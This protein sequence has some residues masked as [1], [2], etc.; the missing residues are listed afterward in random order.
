MMFLLVIL[1]KYEHKK[2]VIAEVLAALSQNKY[3]VPVMDKFGG[4]IY[5]SLII[6]NNDLL[7]HT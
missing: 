5:I 1:Q 3:L 6:L 7:P 2:E 4:S